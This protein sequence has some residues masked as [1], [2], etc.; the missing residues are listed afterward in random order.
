MVHAAAAA[1]VDMAANAALAVVDCVR[2]HTRTLRWLHGA[3]DHE[4]NA[5][6]V[7]ASYFHVVQLHPTTVSRLPGC[8]S[9]RTRRT[10]AT[11]SRGPTPRGG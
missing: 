11:S 9:W 3:A 10:Y 5:A 4:R 2:Q 1:A 7:R 8:L 6:E